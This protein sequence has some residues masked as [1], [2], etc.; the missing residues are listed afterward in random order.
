MCAGAIHLA[1]DFIRDRTGLVLK[2]CAVFGQHR[3]ASEGVVPMFATREALDQADE[4]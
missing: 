4:S 1:E 2:K 3:E